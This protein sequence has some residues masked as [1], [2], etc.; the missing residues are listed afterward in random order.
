MLC[1]LQ[2]EKNIA[3]MTSGNPSSKKKQQTKKEMFSI[4]IYIIR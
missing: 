4:I 1:D 2:R 3:E